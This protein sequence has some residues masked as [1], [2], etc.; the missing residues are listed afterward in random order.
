[1][2]NLSQG[3][4][5]GARFQ[6]GTPQTRGQSQA[7]SP[8]FASGLESQM[9]A[10]TWGDA[11]PDLALGDNPAAGRAFRNATPNR[12]GVSA[13][14]SS[15]AVAGVV[16]ARNPGEQFNYKSVPSPETPES[17]APA[18]PNIPAPTDKRSEFAQNLVRSKTPPPSVDDSFPEDKVAQLEN[19][20]AARDVI[21]QTVTN[22]VDA[23]LPRTPAPTPVP[24]AEVQTADNRFSTFSLNVSDVSFRLAAATLEKGQMPEPGSVRP[25]EFLNAFDYHDPEPAAGVK[26]SFAWDRCAVPFAHHRDFLRF[27]LKTAAEGREGSR[28]LNI[29]LLLDKS[30]SMERAD[31]VEITRKML[32]A[33]GSQLRAAD[34]LSV[35]VFARTPRLWADGVAGDKAA[36]TLQWVGNITPEGGTDLEA[37]M[38]VAYETALR[39]YATNGENRVV[40]LTDGAANLGEIDPVSLK[41]MVGANRA[42]GVAF[43]CFGVGWEGYNDELLEALSRAG[44]GRYGFINK[45]EDAAEQFAG[46]LAGALRVAAYDVKAQVEFNPRRVTSWRQIGYA[47]DQL[48]REQFRDN[49]V[50]AA[51]LGA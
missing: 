43:D 21:T 45:P 30:G 15:E 14:D 25:E 17:T 46:Q 9:P 12:R 49:S 10:N 28:P 47:K 6:E 36:D 16:L 33:L 13:R 42:Q 11:T 8:P 38:R 32:E 31:R 40:L 27:G 26:V 41:K 7:S 24:A 5:Q 18:A 44:G 3:L 23:P 34:T 29:V 4:A 50:K 48:T 51:Q 39:H 22:V 2:P 1:V 37:A 19:K 20:E 35:V